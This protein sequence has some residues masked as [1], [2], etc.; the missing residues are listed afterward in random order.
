METRRDSLLSHPGFCPA[1]GVHLTP[2]V[3]ESLC[4]GRGV[5]VCQRAVRTQGDLTGPLP[6][7]GAFVPVDD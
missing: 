4:T 7:P 1:D 6:R 3:S 2:L 5:P